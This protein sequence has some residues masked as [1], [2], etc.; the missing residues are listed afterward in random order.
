M[1]KQELVD[2]VAKGAGISNKDA[3][4]ALDALASVIH[5]AVTKGE[6]VILPKVGKFTRKERAARTGRNPKTGETMEIA[7]GT[8][9]AFKPTKDFREA[10]S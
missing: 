9:P 6:E 10:V 2:A 5:S 7:A 8:V 1:T 3:A 4:A